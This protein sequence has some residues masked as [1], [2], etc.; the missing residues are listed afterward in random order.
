MNTC[1]DPNVLTG[2]LWAHKKLALTHTH[3]IPAV[4]VMKPTFKSAIIFRTVLMTVW[5]QANLITDL[6]Y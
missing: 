5:K 3:Q 4:L 6:K 2:Y 1:H